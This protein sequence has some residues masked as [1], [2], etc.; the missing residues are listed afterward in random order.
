MEFWISKDIHVVL[1][2]EHEACVFVQSSMEPK[3]G[4]FQN[5]KHLL[6]VMDLCL[7][8]DSKGYLVPNK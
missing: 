1:F 2:R 8:F 4:L 3:V 6:G 5:S 7:E